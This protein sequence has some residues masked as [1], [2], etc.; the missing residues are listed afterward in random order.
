MIKK[1]IENIE[2]SEKNNFLLK[3]NFFNSNKNLFYFLTLQQIFNINITNI[4]IDE[5]DKIENDYSIYNCLFFDKIDYIDSIIILA[6]N[7][8]YILLN[9]N[10]N[11]LN[12]LFYAQNK[13]SKKFWILNQFEDL[14]NE[15]CEYLNY[16]YE[17][18][19]NNNND[20]YKYYKKDFK[21]ISF[22][23]N[24]INELHKKQFLHQKIVSKFF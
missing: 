9:F 16:D 3:F 15:Q 18:N 21:L 24:E 19:I 12:T 6:R 5:N 13:I 4:I 11:N 8:I 10:V 1:N 23:Y 17:N 20:N 7:K 14:L 22:N 2:N